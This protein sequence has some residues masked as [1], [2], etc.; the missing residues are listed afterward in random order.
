M[1]DPLIKKSLSIFLFSAV[2]IFLIHLAVLFAIGK[3]YETPYWYL[4]YAFLVPISFLGIQ[5][6]IKR[7]QKSKKVTS[8][9]KNYIA[10]TALKMILAII[11]LLP[12]LLNKDETSKPMVIH[13]FVVFF[14]FLLVET[15]LLVRL[16]NTPLDEKIKNEE[17]Q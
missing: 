17:N 4:S 7:Y 1:N 16:L 12:W 9:G 13:F 3:I 15:I 8:I 10:Y 5:I 2:G 14:P 6:I 11:F